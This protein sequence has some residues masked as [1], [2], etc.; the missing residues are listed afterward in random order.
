VTVDA[1][2]ILASVEAYYTGKLRA[3][4]ATPQGVDWNSAE[5]QALRFDELLRVCPP[6]GAF[7]LLDYGCGYGALLAHLRARGAPGPYLGFDI[8]EPM[9]AE[10]RRQHARDTAARFTAEAS[11]LAP[12]DYVVASG[13]FNVRL[14]HAES[15][16]E[17]YVLRTLARLDGL[18]RR[19]FAFNALSVYSDPGRRRPDLHYAD[20]RALFDHCKRAFSPRVALLHDYPLWEFTILVRKDG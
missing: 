19:G 18:A 9:V 12:A 16:W 17:R 20:P 7:S 5:S 14:A 10:A 3:H 1:A 2:D 13:I 6:A 15:E 11:V 8:S 4:G